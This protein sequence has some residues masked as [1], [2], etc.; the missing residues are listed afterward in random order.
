MYT[1]YCTDDAEILM[2]SRDFHFRKKNKP[3]PSRD[4][5]QT[6]PSR[7]NTLVN[8]YGDYTMLYILASFTSLHHYSVQYT[9]TY[10]DDIL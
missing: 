3:E 1:V 2:P 5:S 4:Y 10:D 7:V 9:L 8:R 6:S